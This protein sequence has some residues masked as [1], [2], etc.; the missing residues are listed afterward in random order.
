MR[1]RELNNRLVQFPAEVRDSIVTELD[2]APSTWRE[3][4]PASNK[5]SLDS[6][7]R[8]QHQHEL[9]SALQDATYDCD[10][11]HAA[12]GG[13]ALSSLW[14]FILEAE[15]VVTRLDM[16]RGKIRAFGQAAEGLYR[17]TPYH[18][19]VHAAQV[20]LAMYHLL[21]GCA[22]REAIGDIPSDLVLL[23]AYTACV[24]HDLDHP[25]VT[26]SLLVSTGDSRAL[27]YNDQSV[28]EHHH[29][30]RFFSLLE[31][32][33]LNIFE[34][35]SHKGW[36]HVRHLII[37]MV[38]KT[39]MHHHFNVVRDC[40]NCETPVPSLLLLQVTLKLADISHA[41][42]LDWEGHQKWT[43]RM[44]EELYLQGDIENRLGM[45]VSV[46]M[47][48]TKAAFISSQAGFFDVFV[49]PLLEVLRKHFPDA[50]PWVARATSNRD[51]WRSFA[52]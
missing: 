22:I 20:L 26:N 16:D 25:G 27:R 52:K 46:F 29:L 8:D 21:H 14:Q 38:L 50:E 48:R 42:A 23:S 36:Q 11:L 31:S 35:T 12:T 49:L 6:Q 30:A 45:P 3:R 7:L 34:N 17:D 39:D 1:T 37:G 44:E 10:V 9:S 28:N 40:E 24:V 33:S 2:P 43:G 32:P 47:D 18:N 51:R 13:H 19:S 5:T 4:S 41:F 15:G